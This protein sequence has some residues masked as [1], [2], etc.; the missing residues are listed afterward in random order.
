[1][2]INKVPPSLCSR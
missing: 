1:M 2:I